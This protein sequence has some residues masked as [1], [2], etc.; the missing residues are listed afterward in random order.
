MTCLIYK[1]IAVNFNLKNFQVPTAALGE[2]ENFMSQQN[3]DDFY[4]YQK[5]SNFR[6]LYEMEGDARQRHLWAAGA[7]RC[8][9]LCLLRSVTHRRI[10]DYSFRGDHAAQLTE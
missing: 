3:L 4:K 7:T 1:L 10:F 2:G 8:N 9:L 5:K 6:W